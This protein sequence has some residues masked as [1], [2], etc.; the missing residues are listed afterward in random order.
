MAPRQLC[1]RSRHG[2]FSWSR[3]K[4]GSAAPL[5]L[6]LPVTHLEKAFAFAILAFLFPL[7]CVLLHVFLK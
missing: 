3:L 7:A 1:A 6:H 4:A 2:A 5:T